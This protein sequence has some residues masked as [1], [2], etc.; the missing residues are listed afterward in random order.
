LLLAEK[1]RMP[2]G[3]WERWLRVVWR[4]LLPRG[5][6]QS[7]GRAALLGAPRPR[8]VVWRSNKNRSQEVTVLAGQNWCPYPAVCAPIVM[9]GMVMPNCGGLQS[10]FQTGR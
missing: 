10:L 6:K 5:G 8:Q 1:V 7:R 9:G 2:H 4:G 3:E